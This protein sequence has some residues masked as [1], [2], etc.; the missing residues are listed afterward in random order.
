MGPGVKNCLK[1][2]DVIYRRPL[3]KA[4]ASQSIGQDNAVNWTNFEKN[5][6]YRFGGRGDS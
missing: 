5:S 6:G 4:A 1:L 2:R 3:T